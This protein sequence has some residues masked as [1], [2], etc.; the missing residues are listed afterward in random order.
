[1][2]LDIFKPIINLLPELET[3]MQKPILK[4]RLMWTGFALLI[5]TILGVYTLN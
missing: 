5:F 3:P 4:K 2:K 1:M